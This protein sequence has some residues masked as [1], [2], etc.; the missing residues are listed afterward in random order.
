MPKTLFTAKT[1]Y[2]SYFQ[3]DVDYTLTVNGEDKIASVVSSDDVGGTVTLS[4]KTPDYTLEDGAS[5]T[6]ELSL[7]EKEHVLA[8]PKKALSTINGR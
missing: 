1:E 2:C 6:I 8:I 7:E 3:P 5:G 4:L